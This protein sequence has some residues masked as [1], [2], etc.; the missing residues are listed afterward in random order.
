[1]DIKKY[2]EA[3]TQEERMELFNVL[4]DYLPKGIRLNTSLILPIEKN[5]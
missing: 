2:I 5:T 4:I 3:L 1:M